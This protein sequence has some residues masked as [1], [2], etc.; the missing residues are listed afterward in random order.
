MEM[1][2]DYLYKE[3]VRLSEV[4]EQ[5]THGS[6]ED[7]KLLGVLGAIAAWPPVATWLQSGSDLGL[8]FFTGF[9]VMMLIVAIIGT[10]D[11]MKQSLIEYYTQQLVSYEEEI[12]RRLDLGES[13]T[14]QVASMSLRWVDEVHSKIAYRFQVLFSLLLIVFPIAVL[15]SV[16]PRWYAV[17]YAAVAVVIYLIYLDARKSLRISHLRR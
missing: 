17:V 11:L 9:V 15:L 3:Y 4:V 5:L 10:R 12:R 14:F 2:I 13:T 8:V 16:P 6:F 1:T 7:F